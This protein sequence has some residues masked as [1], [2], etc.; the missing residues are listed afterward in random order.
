MKAYERLK[1]YQNICKIRKTVYKLSEK[2]NK[3]IRLVSQLRDAARSAKQN[4][5]EGYSKDSAG[6]FLH[7][8]KIAKGSLNEAEGDV[9]DCFRILQIF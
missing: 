7:S 4:I 6:E 9:N 3:H 2:F 5:I 8:I 1:F